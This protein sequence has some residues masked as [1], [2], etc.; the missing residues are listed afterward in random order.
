MRT[1]LAF[2]AA[3]VAA[4][5]SLTFAVNGIATS[6][7]SGGLI[8]TPSASADELAPFEDCE[9]LRQWYV[10]RA[11]KKVGPYGFGGYGIFYRRDVVDVTKGAVPLAAAE[12]SNASPDEAVSSSATGTNV[13]EA[14]VDEPDRAKTDGDLVVHL[15]GRTLVVTDVT[16]GSPREVGTLRLPRNLDSA[17]LL[18]AGDRVLV[19]GTPSYGWG[20]DPMPVDMVVPARVLPPPMD[21]NSRLLEVSIADPASP[22]IVSDQTF[23]GTLLSARQYDDTVR[24]VLRTG[25]PTLDFV[26]PDRDR[27]RKEA[28]AANQA[29]VRNSTV[30]DWLPSLRLDGGERTPL[31]EC[32]DVRHPASGAGFGTITVVT[33]PAADPTDLA[34]TA[35]T[36]G[37]DLVY[38]STDRLY[39]ATRASG[40]A[41]DVHAFALD[42]ATT[43]YLASGRV[44]GTIRDRWSMDSYEGALRIAVAHGPEWSPTDNG[45]TVLQERGGDLVVVGSVRDLGP[46]EEI[47]SVRW[48]DDLALVVTFRQT[49]PLYTVDLSDPT[50]PRTLGKL[51][52][53]GFSEYLHP[54]GDDRL[55]GL[56]QDASLRGI[57]RG[58]QASMFDV[59]DLRDPR[60]IDTLFLG[61]HAMPATA[62][63]PRTFTWLGSRALVA[64]EDQWN[65]RGSLVEILVGDDGTLTEGE[66][67]PLPR[68]EAPMART[69]P[70]GD[71]SGDG[72]VALVTRNVRL[73]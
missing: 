20:R 66:R 67:W 4:T 62:Y 60:R 48:F 36:A 70:L 34:T 33:L 32:E 68:W 43:S 56:G 7:L 59:S 46:K 53:P 44:D 3:A 71:S 30:E 40:R 12:R 35:V 38:S 29:I 50:R 2:G 55:L 41:T 10:D 49:D 11:V 72:A 69:L 6:Q 16:S 47:K 57:V 23:G 65:G 28:K 15:R 5:A 73:L 31:V 21:Q 24:V 54:V 8:R 19:T 37:G 27:T 26:F 14:G 13:Q 17:E 58:G 39:L 42:G 25:E 64:V 18:L 52:I 22:R 9:E 51:K 61:K 1:K 45:I 63:D